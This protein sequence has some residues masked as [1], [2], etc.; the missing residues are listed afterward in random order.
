M[1]NLFKR[2][3]IL[4]ASILI[5]ISGASGQQQNRPLI[6]YVLK[7][8]PT[9][10]SAFEIEIHLLH[11][12]HHFRMAMATHH[13]YDDRFWRFIK[14]FHVGTSRGDAKFER[15]D[16]AVW[17]ITV[18]D[19]DAVISYRLVLPEHR[20]FAHRPFLASYGG[21][22]GD[23][24]SFLYL[25]GYD[26]VPC[27]VTFVLPP[28]WQIATGLES[29][30]LANTF[31]AS[32]AEILMDCPVLAGHLHQWRFFVGRVP[33]TVAYLPVTDTLNFDSTLLV[34][35]IRKIVVQT[36]RL[37]GGMPYKNYVFMLEDGVYGALE[38][39]NSVTIGAPARVLATRMQEMYE[40][41]AHE[42]SHT[43]NLLA[44]RP[45]EYTGLNYGPQEQSS[46]LWFS[47]GM[48]MFYADLLVRRAGLPA[49]DSTRITHLESLI[50]RYYANPGNMVIPPAKVSLAEN[51]APGMLGDYSASTHLQGE[52]LGTMLD[53]MIRSNT[54]GR[55]SFDDVMRLM[56]QRF[57]G[58]RGGGG[59]GG[60]EGRRGFYARDIEQAVQDVCG[61]E[62]IHPFFQ[63]YIY[64]GKALDFNT[65]LPLIG[66]QMQLTWQ[67]VAD[68]KGKLLPDTRVYIW[69][70]AGD[71]VFRM[72]MTDPGSCWVKAGLHTGDTVSAINGALIKNRQDFYQILHTFQI[73]DSIIV[74]VR[75]STGIQNVMVSI[76]GYLAPVVHLLSKD[77]PD[78][79]VPVIRRDLWLRGAG[80]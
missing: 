62:S 32:S 1:I 16:S 34:D 41:I 39:G 13:E 54:E 8:D 2:L 18:P 23:I 57:W 49:E 24:H 52:L 37:F 53:L 20:S 71:T 33:H 3:F 5:F 56:Y 59:G 65:W 48:A 58:G 30:H 70:P 44:I 55:R 78:K 76:T 45:A 27:S 12:P 75:R 25:A 28:G 21:L 61:G 31:T 43:W 11:I 63:I 50:G 14:N 40:E 6:H 26:A 19:Q 35:N 9:D 67:P 42:F 15:T 46:L 73:G 69:Q 36:V 64:E 38:H 72:A 79:N 74:Q 10:L 22:L 66:L 47:E 68:E 51:A 29:T 4:V 7:V 60:G 77:G 17:S 80:G